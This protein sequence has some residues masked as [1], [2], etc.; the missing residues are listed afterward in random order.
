M[1]DERYQTHEYIFGDQ[2]CQWLIMNRH[3]LPHSGTA[4]A[5][6]DGEGRNGVFLAEIG[7]DVTSIDL[8]EVGLNKARNLA[9][10]RGVKIKTIHAD[11][12]NY[13]MEPESQDLVA[14]IYCHL[15]E[16]IRKTVH[17][18]VETALKPGGVYILEAFHECQLDY[19]S[20][21]PK[22]LDLLYNLE[23]LINDFRSLQILEAC[24]G[25]CHLE[26]GSRHSGLGYIVRLVLQKVK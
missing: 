1:W 24:Q 4:L 21:G 23:A 3:R 7:L 11:L 2:P 12:E 14:S 8:S 18:R 25:L 26:E 13:Q 22:T 15:P 5:L 16:T 6:G 9:K 20:G 19:Q 10:T 17:Q